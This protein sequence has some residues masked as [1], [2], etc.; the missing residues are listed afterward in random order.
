M[1][2]SF[3]PPGPFFSRPPDGWQV[4]EALEGRDVAR[5]HSQNVEVPS[6]RV[7]PPLFDIVLRKTRV[8]L[9]D[10]VRRVSRMERRRKASRIE[11]A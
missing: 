6:T 2:Q 4:Y 9:V 8:T 5:Q 7:E 11:A 3:G 1:F 10:A